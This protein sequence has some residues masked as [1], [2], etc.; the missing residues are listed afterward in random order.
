MR[1]VFE[2]TMAGLAVGSIYALLALGYVLVYK[3][4]KVFNLA[5]GSLVLIGAYLAFALSEKG[6]PILLAIIISIFVNFLLGFVVEKLFLRPML[7][8][9]LPSLLLLTIGLMETVKG[10]VGMIFGNWPK[11]YPPVFPAGNLNLFGK[12]IALTYVFVAAASLILYAVFIWFYQKSSLGLNMRAVATNQD[13]AS[14][15]GINVKRV[16]ALSWGFAGVVGAIGGAF[17]AALLFLNL[18]LDL[19]AF[20]ALP[21]A[22]LG[23]VDSVLGALVGGLILGLAESVIAG[24]VFDPLLGGGT[25]EVFGYLVMLAVLFI[26]PYG[27]FGTEEIERL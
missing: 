1:K 17:L 13:R 6:V 21:A 5:Q 24:G 22:L 4:T 16:F 11:L 23:G 2:L 27:L 20:R 26:R 12:D 14:L 3:S 18:T 10:V 19:F 25:K 7:G 8:K 9:P 15:M